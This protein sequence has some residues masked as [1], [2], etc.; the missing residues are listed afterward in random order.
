VSA[1]KPLPFDPLAEAER[2]WTSHG[3]GDAAAGMAAVLSI[4]RAERIIFSR[5]RAALD[6]L[7]ITFARY[8]VLMMLYFS[9]AGTLP[10]GKISTRSHTKPGSITNA[11]NHLEGQ[12]YIRRK[13]HPVDGRT[14]LAEITPAGRDVA[15]AATQRLNQ[16]LFG[17]LGCTE[18]DTRTLVTLLRHFRSNA[19]DFT[20]SEAEATHRAETLEAPSSVTPH[21]ESGTAAVHDLLQGRLPTP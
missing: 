20:E 8:E 13:P 19:G 7:E 15:L 9:S 10:L 11:C 12:G 6:P 16:G 1:N 5:I 18:A 21:K 14:T 4:I 3:W 2:H 17:S